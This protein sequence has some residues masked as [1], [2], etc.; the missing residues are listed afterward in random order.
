M[1]QRGRGQALG[2]ERV[3]VGD[4]GDPQRLGDEGHVLPLNVL[5]HHDLG[6]GHVVQRKVRDGVAEDR[7]LDE[8]HVAPGG[9]DRLH[10]LEDVVALLLQ[11]A[12]HVL[13]VRHHH[14]HVQVRL[15]RGDVELHQRNAGVLD[16]RGGPTHRRRL[17]REHQP[18]HHL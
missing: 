13:V 6:L 2:L 17:L 18:V 1:D 10:H 14:V 12:V 8:Q 5:D 3:D 15:G 11:D 4:R 7:L 16:P 9:L